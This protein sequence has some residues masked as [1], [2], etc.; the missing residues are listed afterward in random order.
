MPARLTAVPHLGMLQN[1]NRTGPP[2]LGLPI[3]LPFVLVSFA[4]NSLITRYVVQRQLLDAGLLTA[5]R[6]VSGALALL[7]LAVVLRERLHVGRANLVP[8]LWL[9]VYAVCISYG[10]LFIG[11]AAGTFVFYASVL[12]TL[13]ASDLARRVSVPR[14]RLAGAGVAL[15]GLAVLATQA[16]GAVTPL[17][18][19]L[20][21]A[22]GVAWGLYTAAGRSAAD[23]RAAT[24]GHFVVLAGVLV[25]P[26]GV[27]FS[28]AVHV[29]V[30]GTGVAWGAVMGAGTTAFAYIAWYACQRALSAT[31]AGTVQ[32]VIPVLTAVGAVLLLGERI[33][34]GLAVAAL[35]VGAG[36]WLARIRAVPP[37][38]TRRVEVSGGST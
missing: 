23:P 7:L 36:M 21:S 20:L 4:V 22:T 24:T 1:V 10:Y 34:P 17:G 6:F 5:V 28:P 29:V 9:G 31:S 3:L 13:L 12:L 37:D 8:A 35:L 26:M 19:V 25:L 16:S 2:T 11:A 32:L 27:L 38:R 15:A 18:V 14:R 30:T 33:T